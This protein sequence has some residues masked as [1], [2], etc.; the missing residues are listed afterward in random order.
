MVLGWGQGAVIAAALTKPRVIEV[1][2]ASKTCQAEEAL[3][4][5][6]SWKHLPVALAAHPLVLTA[7]LPFE[8]LME[9]VPESR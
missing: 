8:R 7:G 5:A 3:M 1:A 4:L 9:A 6:Q 2:L